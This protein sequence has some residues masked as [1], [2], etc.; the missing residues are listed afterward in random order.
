MATRASDQS[1]VRSEFP[2]APQPDSDRT[3]IIPTIPA[4]RESD[5][6]AR[7]AIPVES[8]PASEGRVFRSTN[9]KPAGKQIPLDV[10]V[11]F[12]EKP[13]RE[14]RTHRRSRRHTPRH[15]ASGNAGSPGSPGTGGLADSETSEGADQPT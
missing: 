5:E 8:G 10:E 7:I 2:T 15:G 9:A 12:V 14:P 11:E 1:S 13:Q 4:Q 3:A 6:T